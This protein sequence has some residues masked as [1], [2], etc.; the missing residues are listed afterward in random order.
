MDLDSINGGTPATKGWLNPVCGD[1]RAHDLYADNLYLTGG[2]S[3]IPGP[4]GPPGEQ[5]PQG[6]PGTSASIS[7]ESVTT[8]APGSAVIFQNVG[9][10]PSA[11]FVVS[12]PRGDPGVGEQGPP[13]NPGAQGPAGIMTVG[14][15]T[16]GAPGSAVSFVNVGSPENATFD[17]SIPRG[18]VGSQGPQGDPGPAGA[19]GGS[20]SILT[21]RA[22]TTTL[23]P[24]STIGD[25]VWNTAGQTDATLIYLSHRQVGGQDVERI[26]EIATVGSTLLVQAQTNSGQYQT[27]TM[28][29]PPVATPGAYVTFFVTLDDTGGALFTNNNNLLVSIVVKG[30][31]GPEGPPGEAGPPG[32]TGAQGDPGPP[33]DAATIT[34]GTTTTGA[35]GTSASVVAVG[36]TAAQIFD[37]TIPTGAAGPPGAP[38][39]QGDPGPAGAAATLT[40]GSTTTG[41]AGSAALVTQ[42]GT[43]A[44]RVF[45]FTIPTGT[46]GPQGPQGIQGNAGPAGTTPVFSIGTVN[47]ADY[48][49][50][51]ATVD[52][53]NPA[54]PVL[55][56]VVPRGPAGISSGVTISNTGTA[57]VQRLLFTNTANGGT[58]TTLNAHATGLNYVP[59]TQVLT[60][61]GNI[62]AVSF[63]GPLT[64]NASS[65]TQV[66]TT[67]SSTTSVQYLAFSDANGGLSNLRTATALTY[68]PGEVGGATLRVPRI[69]A[70]GTITAPS[71]VGVASDAQQVMTVTTATANTRYLCLTPDN[72][73]A[74]TAADIQT[75]PGLS[76]VPSTNILTVGS[77]AASTL[78]GALTGNASTATRV[79]TTASTVNLTRFITFA[80]TNNSVGA[81]SDIQTAPALTYVPQS[82]LLS[83]GSVTAAAFSG[84]LTGNASSATQ[85]ATIR[86]GANL[87]RYL[88]FSPSDNSVAANSDVMT[89][90][91]LTYNPSTAQLSVQNLTV[92]G[93]L[94]ASV[95]SATNLSGT[96]VASLPYQSASGVT[97]YIANGA[98]NT[99]LT[100]RGGTLSPQWSAPSSIIRGYT[101]AFGSGGTAAGYQ[102][103]NS[104]AIGLVNVPVG[105]GITTKFVVPI[106]G[107]IE[108]ATVVWGTG[109]A[110]A[111]FSILKDAVSAYTSGA[112]FTTAGTTAITSGMFV[113]VAAGNVIEVRTNNFNLGN[114]CVVLYFT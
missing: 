98:T 104:G 15:V 81:A 83:V 60:S 16:T 75:A 47:A 102:Y 58:A 36:T 27:F 54:A 3:G 35:P 19:P 31:P 44:A 100:S 56:F 39:A 112:V 34:V 48:P 89:A 101:V 49:T 107:S 8:G 85:V 84:P 7:V 51:S 1:L 11:A 9:A 23:L 106:A 103:A 93:T 71:F 61:T 110:T 91:V 111:T 46:Q 73:S 66:T 77:V 21:Y 79:T 41:A 32:A 17:I 63:S 33:G 50:C 29:E 62:T 114:M 37:F 10:G 74:S 14:T 52:V 97:S 80:P 25:L 42:S 70:T 99:I 26:L 13:G 105:S 2:G 95:S 113:G 45:D 72:N 90:T 20:A 57:N 76:Y 28:T 38:G 67:N 88:L 55:S 30:T 53:T 40:V 43:S 108:A 24:V 92:T 87:T 5:G 64:G 69:I 78:S 68:I 109:S 94:S 82:G 65:A 22:N 18:D 96:S 86:N 6:P 12:I 4:P 59:Q